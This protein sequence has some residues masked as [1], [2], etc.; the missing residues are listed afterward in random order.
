MTSCKQRLILFA[1]LILLITKAAGQPKC[2]IEYYSTENGLSHQ[3]VTCILKDHEGFMWFGTWDGINRFDGHSF[4]SYKS[5]PGDLSQLGNSR[6]EQIVE[7]QSDHLWIEAYDR[8]IYRFDKKYGQFRPLSPVINPEMKH[9]ISFSRI[10][11]AS[12]GLVWLQSVNEG[13]FC[14]PQNDLS[15][16]HIHI[17]KKGSAGEYE[18]SSNTI[19]FFH[20]D[21]EKLIWIGTPEGLTCLTLSKSGIYT[22]SKTASLQIAAGKDF[23]AFDEDANRLYFG[24]ADGYLITFEKK[25][26]S[27]SVRKITSARLNALLRSKKSD[28][29][30]A[31]T[32]CGQLINYILKNETIK[33]ISYCHNEPFTTLYE[34]KK[35]FLWIAPEKKGVVRFDPASLSFNYYFRKNTER[36]N[37]P[38]NPFSV[39]EDN[40]GVTWVHMKGGGFGY[41]DETSRSIN[42]IL[43]TPEAGSAS[44]PA[45]NYRIYYDS[46]G[47]FWVTTN[48]KQLL[49]ILLQ[50]NVFE[51]HLLVEEPESK[52]ANEIRGICCDHKNRL[53]LG[54]K[55]GKMYVYQN[56]KKL[57]GIFD[58]EPA[59]GPGQ[60]YAILQDS[61]G[62]MWLGTK[63]N[64][65]YKALPVNKEETKY[66]LIHYL[67]AKAN[68]NSLPCNDIYALLE[69]RQGRM[70]VGS[71][72][73]GLFLVQE[74]GDSVKLVQSGDAFKNYPK[75]IF[76][77]I[78]HLTLDSAGNIWIGS[79]NGLL[80]LDANDRHSPVYRYKPYR[81]I[82]GDVQSLGNNDIQFIFRDS[83]NRMWLATSG[84]GFCKA[85][86]DQ[87]FTFLTFKNYTTKNG[88]PNDYVLSCGE[89][90]LGNLWITTENGLS[91][92]APENESF[93]NYDSYYGLA[94]VS[95]SEAAVCH[96]TQNDRLFYGSNRGYICFEPD[97]I[98]NDNNRITANIAFTGLRINNERVQPG[99]NAPL[100]E[101]INYVS[102][103]TLQHNQNIISIDYAML[104]NRAGKRLALVYRL[105]GFDSVWHDDGLQRR[106]TYTNL[107]PGQYVFEVRSATADLYSNNP[108][109]RLSITI[110]PPP[111]K[112]WWAYL[113]YAIFILLILFFI[114]RT[115][116]AMIKLRNKITV[117]QKLAALKVNFFTN[118]SHELR[119]PLTL[120][121][122]PIEQLAKKEKLTA[123]GIAY[124]ETAKK[125]AGRMI[126]FINQLLD[127]RKI[128]SN[129]AALHVSR[130]EIVS[131]V[132]K[133]AE[134]FQVE[135]ESRGVRLNLIAE[136]QEL[137]A[138]ADAEKLDIVLYNLLANAVKF[139]PDGKLINIIIKC[140][141]EEQ[142]FSIEVRDQGPGVEEEKLKDIFELFYE[143]DQPAFNAQKGS[144]IGLALSRELVELHGGNIYAQN[145]PGGG[146]AVT[147]KL[148]LGHH[149]FK[150][151]DI[152]N[153][154]HMSAVYDE[155]PEKQLLPQEPVNTAAVDPE[156]PLLLLVE[157]NDDLRAFLE[158]QL[159]EHYRVQVARDG[160]A[161]W[162]QALQLLPDV[163]V[164]DIM[165]PVMDGI[166]MLDKIKNDIN[167]S[168]IPVVLLSAR[169]SIESQIEGLQY[170]ADHYITKPFNNEFLVAAIDN[171][172][173]QRKNLFNTLVNKKQ[174]IEIRPATVVVTTG[175]ENFLKEV[176]SIVEEKMTDPGFNLETVAENMKMSR[177]NFYKKFKS[178][179]GIVPVEFVRDMRLQRARQYLDTGNTNISEVAYLSGFSSPKYFSTC[180]REKFHVTPSDYIKAKT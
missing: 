82:P 123:E 21:R 46:S 68:T 67:P 100:K 124:V 37:I 129:K 109:R 81:K 47:V 110:L 95:F 10:L 77:K 119:T 29:L 155:A 87:P 140:L 165:M 62:N 39:F 66:H 36:L 35:G 5:S 172:L 166:Q 121:V 7:D 71:F 58:N 45:T 53:W 83:K 157:D 44:L 34:D 106:T 15:P 25:T 20:E 92:L 27:F 138:W 130:L 154:K 116:L 12:N 105:L 143:G 174:A 57:T 94:N 96:S 1:L 19:N 75:E 78:R 144:G 70:W 69:D 142:Y 22:N 65:L 141:C 61:R 177:S 32:N 156:A 103:L 49:K 127:L 102:Q 159:S 18:L 76:N 135:L 41:Y 117:E 30:Y 107:P 89:D 153:T 23:T 145:N 55:N 98:Y 13:L 31:V 6:I 50:G 54:A 131:F 73:K 38:R 180:F 147:V 88:M 101:D 146:L 118:V 52:L 86:G 152:F 175:D 28:C 91:M 8:Q 99:L 167:T 134:H 148:R 126:R 108:Y 137:I 11:S 178:L 9:K 4:L 16:Q 115:A 56:G 150:K 80:L 161:G 43:H 111:W 125:N 136:Q 170:G 128:E 176:I 97:R 133:I 149:H 17:Y 51:Q 164:S 90:K 14:V 26:K 112:T 3:A 40:N 132:K 113:L 72:D 104:N 168:H 33:V 120:I 162:Q 163:I 63:G 85:G 173:R 179:T 74:S 48:E 64:G 93:R 84:G 158:R 151:E 139:T 59:E 122:N 2:K 42:Y 169:H 79:T 24:T 160:A 171:L 60:V 114:R